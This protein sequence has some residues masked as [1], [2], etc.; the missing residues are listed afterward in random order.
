MA[1]YILKRREPVHFLRGKSMQNFSTIKGLNQKRIPTVVFE[2]LDE[3]PE[4]FD[5][6]EA[7]VLISD[8][9]IDMDEDCLRRCQEHR[10]PVCCITSSNH[11]LATRYSCSIISDD[12]AAA[13]SMVY[14]YFHDYGKDRVA[15]FGF[16][17]N[18]YS[19]VN[20][21]DSFY[22]VNFAFSVDD[23]FPIKTG[24]AA[25]FEDFFA[26]R[27]EYDGVYFP[28]DFV[29]LAF[30][31]AMF[32]R[33]PDYLKDRF[34]IGWMCTQMSE[35]YRYPLS[36]VACKT[37]A[38]KN[39]VIQAYRTLAHD[40]DEFSSV[41][42]FLNCN[43]VV[44]QSTG[45][46]SRHLEYPPPP[47]RECTLTHPPVPHYD[48][49]S[50]PALKDIF[51]LEELFSDAKELDRLIFY[52]LLKGYSAAQ[53]ADRLFLSQQTLNR[54]KKIYT[55]KTGRAGWHALADL[56]RHYITLPNLENQIR[57]FAD[58]QSEP[59]DFTKF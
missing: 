37:Y 14:E 7:F 36:T 31:D 5:D 47:M 19:D 2:S 51:A 1:L 8:S 41:Q 16:Y 15:F 27:A 10:I 50:D 33:D 26:R 13:A 25:C 54:R 44:R 23:I 3:V 45:N 11:P 28:N 29:A 43:L 24:I 42:I 52:L 32:S 35:L 40:R 12:N 30:L 38:Q 55:E 17:A 20:K 39:A 53:I 6:P 9:L 49:R 34:F 18:S 4:I 56:L 46:R 59:I 48:H 22:R 58:P 21:V 57:R